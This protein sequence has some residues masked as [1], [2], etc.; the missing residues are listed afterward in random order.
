M[1]FDSRNFSYFNLEKLLLSSMK[2]GFFLIILTK[3]FSEI[4]IFNSSICISKIFFDINSD[5]S[6]STI[7]LSIFFLITS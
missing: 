4:F 3:F 6:S 7:L 1:L 5:S 2:F